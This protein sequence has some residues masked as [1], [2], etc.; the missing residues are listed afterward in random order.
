MAIPSPT[1]MKRIIAKYIGSGNGRDVMAAK[2]TPSLRRFR[3]YSAVGRKAFLVEDLEDGALPLYDKDPI[4]P[5]YVIAEGGDSIIALANSER[6]FAPLF[7]IASL[8]LI[9]LSQIR[10]RRFDLIKRSIELGVAGVKEK[11]DVR[12]F[13]TINALSA[14]ADNPHTDIAVSAPLTADSLA[15]AIG[16]IEST[17]Y[18]RPGSSSTVATT[19]TCA[20]SIAMLSTKR[21]SRHCS[22]QVT[23]ARSTA[24]RSSVPVSCPSVLSTSAESGSTTAVSQSGRNSPSSRRTV[25]TSG[26]WDS[27]SSSR[28]GLSHTISWQTSVLRSRAAK[29][30]RLLRVIQ[31]TTESQNDH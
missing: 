30:V 12:V 3:D 20:S 15:D 24:A 29:S 31:H 25:P 18:G 1:S 8:P 14:D 7:E 23:S 17:V 4:I 21:P 2:M 5:A 13:A 11:E 6:V 28:S 26:R 27:P 19:P 10:E 16:A 9:Q 22:G